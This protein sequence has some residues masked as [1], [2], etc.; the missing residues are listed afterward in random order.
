MRSKVLAVCLRL[1]VTSGREDMELSDIVPIDL[2]L[3]E[4]YILLYGCEIWGFAD[5]QALEKNSSE[6]A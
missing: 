1:P 4:M 6:F 2:L 3:E 5:N